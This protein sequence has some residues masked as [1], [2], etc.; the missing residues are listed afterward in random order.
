MEEKEWE[1]SLTSFNHTPMDKDS[2]RAYSK[3]VKDVRDRLKRLSMSAKQLVTDVDLRKKELEGPVVSSFQ[4]Q[5]DPG[6][7]SNDA[8]TAGIS[9]DRI[10]GK[11]KSTSNI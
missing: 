8:L 6:D 10:S 7:S 1:L 5:L 4:V 9:K 11:R 3:N 2:G